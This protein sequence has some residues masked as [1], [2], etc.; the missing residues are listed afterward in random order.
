MKAGFSLT[1][2]FVPK[3]N[4]NADLDAAE[5]MVAVLKM[6]TVQDVFAIMDRL[7]AHGLVGKQD[8]DLVPL[9]KATQLAA[10]AGKYLPVYIELQNAEDFSIEDVTKYPPYFPLAVE[11]LF[12]LIAFAQPTEA[13][14]KN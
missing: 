3:W 4:G 11:L 10:E 5:Q 2:R 6:P 9:A 13:D 1:K 8:S 14:V 7:S 12:A